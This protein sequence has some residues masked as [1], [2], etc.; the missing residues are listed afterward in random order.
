[1]KIVRISQHVKLLFG[2]IAASAVSQAFCSVEQA[3]AAAL[4]DFTSA[5]IQLGDSPV[6]V[7]FRFTANSTF[8]INSLGFYD[9]QQDGLQTSHAVG[10]FNTSGTLLTSTT[11]AAG[12]A[13]VLDGKFRYANIPSFTLNSGQT[14]V[15][16]GQTTGLDGYTYGNVGTSILGL[17]VDS[18]ITIA[19][20]SSLY[21]YASSLTYPTSFNGYDLY[22]IVNLSTTS[23]STSTSV[24]EPFTI[25]GTLVGGTAAFRMRKKFKATNKL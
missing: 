23:F 21:N 25:I 18:K 1:M 15:I 11:I 20:S 13:G 3:Q 19:P 22:P 16:A 8:N 9:Y 5:P 2:L 10:I 4:Y 24:P 17:S 12:T 14:Y 6:T 7:G